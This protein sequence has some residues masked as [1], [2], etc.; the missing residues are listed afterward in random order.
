MHLYATDADEKRA[1]AS[2]LAVLSVGATLLFQSALDAAKLLV[3]WWVDA[4]SVVGFF[5]LLH[6]LFDS[7]LWR[8]KLG[9]VRFSRIPNL[10][11]EWSG[12]VRSSF[13]GVSTET[14]VTV[15][16][17]QTWSRIA[18]KLETER[19]RSKS[20]IAAVSTEESGQHGVTYEYLNEPKPG[21]LSTMHAHRGTAHLYLSVD[22]TVLDG[23][24]YTGRDRH[25]SGHLRLVRRAGRGPSGV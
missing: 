7:Y 14:Q 3:P 2:V 24:Y 5:G 11:G 25:S 10:S 20:L 1:V 15:H 16:I 12:T 18:I 4:P 6:L 22:G 19:S 9:A 23:D 8:V 17:V 21:A 13:D